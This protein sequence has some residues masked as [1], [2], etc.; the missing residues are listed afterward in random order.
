MTKGISLKVIGRVQGVF[1]REFVKS[2]A[3]S[4]GVRGFVRNEPDGSVFIEAES[5]EDSLKKFI[6]ICREGPF[7]ANVEKVEINY[8][9]ELKKYPDFVVDY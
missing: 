9:D 2:E 4:L 1:Y 7:S 5:N 6:E 3:K 8:L